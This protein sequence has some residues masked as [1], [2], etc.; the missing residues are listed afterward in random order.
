MCRFI[1]ILLTC[2][3]HTKSWVQTYALTH[4]VAC[5]FSLSISPKGKQRVRNETLFTMSQL[6][7]H[8]F[9]SNEIHPDYVRMNI[10]M[11]ETD[12][13]GETRQ[14]KEQPTKRISR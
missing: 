10:F 12:T 14:A 4:T 6:T 5:I 7:T 13:G 8:S 1:N 11:S 3:R 2:R 9:F